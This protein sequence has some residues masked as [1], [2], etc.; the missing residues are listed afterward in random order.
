[1]SPCIAESTGAAI[2]WALASW[3]REVVTPMAQDKAMAKA[4][5]KIERVMS[6]RSAHLPKSGHEREDSDPNRTQTGA[7]S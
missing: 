2:F 7:P 1:M 6:Y 5:G 3:A 4:Q